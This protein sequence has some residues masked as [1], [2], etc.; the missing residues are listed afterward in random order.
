MERKMSLEAYLEDQYNRDKQDIQSVEQMLMS[1][2]AMFAATWDEKSNFWPVRLAA[3]AE[4]VPGRPSAG[5]TSMILSA[6]GKIS[7]E[8]TLRDGSLSE[9]LP[10][11]PKGLPNVPSVAASLAGSSTL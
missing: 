6:V 8:C 11:L 9:S 3:G 1:I 5:T 7:Q 2:A 10:E 4:T